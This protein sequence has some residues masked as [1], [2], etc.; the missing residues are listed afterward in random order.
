MNRLLTLITI[1]SLILP[2]FSCTTNSTVSCSNKAINYPK[3]NECNPGLIYFEKSNSCNI[4]GTPVESSE[5]KD[6]PNN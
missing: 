2:L 1:P 5:L 6:S 4:Y 3:C